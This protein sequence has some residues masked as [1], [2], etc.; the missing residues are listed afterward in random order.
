MKANNSFFELN[1]RNYSFYDA[2]KECIKQHDLHSLRIT[3]GV[4]KNGLLLFADNSIA[5]QTSDIISYLPATPQHPAILKVSFMGLSGAVSPLP[6]QTLENIIY[7]SLEADGITQLYL[8]FFNHNFIRLLFKQHGKYSFFKS[9]KYHDKAHHNKLY[10]IG[11]I[12]AY[13]Q[14]GDKAF[15]LSRLLPFTGLLLSRIRSPQVIEKIVKH[16]FNQPHVSVIEW[17][18]QKIVLSSSSLSVIGKKNAVLGDT[19]LAGSSVTTH[20]T[21][22]TIFFDKLSLKDYYSFLVGRQNHEHLLQL[23]DILLKKRLSY[24]LLLGIDTDGLPDFVLDKKIENHL[25]WTIIL[26]KHNENYLHRTRIS[27]QA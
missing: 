16:F 12:K 8:D 24:D 14:Q 21:K 9:L 3:E 13:A 19:L 11:A 23:M 22:F 20:L 10:D 17:V 15:S 1:I 7:D 5:F 25:G 2:V 27:G 6:G 18:R 4:S 26:K